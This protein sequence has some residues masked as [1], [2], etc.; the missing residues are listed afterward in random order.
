MNSLSIIEKNSL[1][2]NKCPCCGK[3]LIRNGVHVQCANPECPEQAIKKLTYYCTKAEMNSVSEATIRTLYNN[4][5]IED[6]IDLY[7]LVGIPELILKI[8]GFGESKIN[9]L[10]QQIEKSKNCTIVQF[11]DRLGIELVG[12]KALNKLGI[13]TVD[14]FWK[15]NDRQYVIG[16]NLIDYR[17]KNKKGIQE[18]L[19]HMNI[20]ELKMKDV[21]GEYYGSVCMT[22]ADPWK[23]GRKAL[24]KKII[25]MGYES[26]N[27]VTS[28]TTVLVVDDLS[29]ISSK[30]QKAQKLGIRVL[31]YEEF[32]K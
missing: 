26:V 24:E 17:E 2:I 8:D 15:F 12:E 14:D 10:F 20:K 25:E 19:N 22:G 1:L 28:N 7:A 21:D 9:N 3:T 4:F 31:K 23:L 18:L 27:S 16:Q 30:M 13:L 6:Y 5:L 32:F 29:S 11:L